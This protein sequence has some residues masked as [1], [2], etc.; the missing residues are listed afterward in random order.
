MTHIIDFVYYDV[1]RNLNYLIKNKFLYKTTSKKRTK[2]RLHQFWSINGPIL[3][4]F[5]AKIVEL[6]FIF[7][8]SMNIF[9]ATVYY[10][11]RPH[12]FIIYEYE[13]LGIVVK[14]NKQSTLWTQT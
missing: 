2:K 5:T 14:N 8:V 13:L 7:L 6:V 11:C 4:L 1:M 3:C 9:G 12:K 10:T